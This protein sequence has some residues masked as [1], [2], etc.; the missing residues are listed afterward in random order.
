MLFKEAAIEN[1][2]NLPQVIR[3][4]AN[5]VELNDNLAVGGTTVSHGVLAEAAHY[6]Q[7]KGISLVAMIRPRGGHFIYNDTEL[8]IMEADLFTAQSLGVD[9]V[10]FGALRQ[11]G[12]LDTEAMEM[13]L[14][15]AN[16]MEVVMHMAFDQIPQGAQHSALDWLSA[17][18]VSR[19]LTHGGPDLNVPI[20]ENEAHLQDLVAYTQNQD[21]SILPGG[22]ITA[23]NAETVATRLGVSAVHGTG[24]FET[25]KGS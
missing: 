25:I 21:L 5:R 8:K 15:A 24:L 1:F 16:G 12:T 17:H 9:G 18:E 4:G 13:L 20:L 14:G 23:V 19:V 7:D 3:Q 2:T 6:T 11:D 22:G 10:A